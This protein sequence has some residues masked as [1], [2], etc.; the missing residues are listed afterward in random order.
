MRRRA[1]LG[2]AATAAAAWRAV[3]ANNRVRLARFGCCPHLDRVLRDAPGV[4][5]AAASEESEPFRAILDRSDID[6][7]VV[8]VP[9]RLR[10][11]VTILACEAGK[12]VYVMSPISQ[13]IRQGRG[14]V[15]AARR[16]RRVVQAEL[17]HRVV[18]H[19]R[20]AHRV[21]EAGRIGEIRFAA[22][23][24]PGGATA[25]CI[26]LVHQ[27]TG[28]DTPR[29]IGATCQYDGFLLSI[30]HGTAPGAAF[31]GDTGTLFCDPCGYRVFRAPSQGGKPVAHFPGFTANPAQLLVADFLDAVRTRRRPAAD[32]EAA[33]RANR[34]ALLARM[35]NHSGCMLRWDGGKEEIVRDPEPL[36]P[37]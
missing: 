7:V 12:D 4:E 5:L 36:P 22:V 3:G 35:S 17:P 31:Y 16:C 30:E 13:D 11:Y 19:Y 29:T 15:E 6:A 34:V 23:W 2:A 9:E 33:H 37:A 10:A 27:I 26:D 20:D 1:F 25:N 14:M 18:P 24:G 8:A 32:I 21:V 28:R